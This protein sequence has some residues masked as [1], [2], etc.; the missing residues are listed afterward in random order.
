VPDGQVLD[1]S[2]SEVDNEIDHALDSILGKHLS[3]PPP[4]PSDREK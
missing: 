3:Y 1:L 2:G 4:P